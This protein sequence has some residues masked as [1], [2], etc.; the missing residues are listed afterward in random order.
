MLLI[1][2]SLRL[3]RHLLRLKSSASNASI[4]DY[5]WH[6]VDWQDIIRETASLTS[7]NRYSLRFR[8][9][10][11]IW[12]DQLGYERRYLEGFSTVGHD[13]LNLLHCTRDTGEQLHSAGSHGNVVLNTHLDRGGNIQ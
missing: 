10:N 3:N 1:L 12:L 7:E 11:T 9:E 13:I 8:S 5:I 6:N 2:H 4:I